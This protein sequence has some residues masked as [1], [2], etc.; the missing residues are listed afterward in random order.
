ML[1]GK[2]KWFLQ[3]SCSQHGRFLVGQAAL[4]SRNIA[5][6]NREIEDLFHGSCSQF[7]VLVL[8]CFLIGAERATAAGLLLGLPKKAVQKGCFNKVFKGHYQCLKR[9]LKV[10]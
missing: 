3:G 2:W 7:F 10:F 1:I 4:F 6:F 5:F 8:A 9:C